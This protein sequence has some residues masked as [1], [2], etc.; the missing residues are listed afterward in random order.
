M[1]VNDLISELKSFAAFPVDDSK[2]CDFVKTGD[3]EKEVQKTAVAMFGT[4]E[5]IRQAAEWGAGFLIVHEPLTYDHM[6]QTP[7]SRIGDAKWHMLQEHQMTVFRFHDYAHAMDPDLIFEGEILRSGLKGTVVGRD[8]FAV[9]TFELSEP[10]T[11]GELAAVLE[12]RLGIPHVRTAGELN[13]KGRRI[14]CAFGSPGDL[15]DLY[16]DHDFI[17]AGEICEWQDAELARDYAW[18]GENKALLVLGHETSERE[19]MVLLTQILKEKHPECA[20]RYFE[21][22]SVLSR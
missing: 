22:G 13:K 12:E 14:A 19:G 1:T 20:F 5:V 18:M 7:V 16:E 15:Y 2:T 17:L 10:M 4:M 6:D 8:R 11:A 21:S 3:A 9:T